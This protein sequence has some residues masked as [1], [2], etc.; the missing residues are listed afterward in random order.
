MPQTVHLSSWLAF[1]FGAPLRIG[2]YCVGDCG[3]KGEPQSYPRSFMGDCACVS[4][5]VGLVFY[6]FFGRSLRG[7]RLISRHNKR[8]LMHT[9][10]RG[11][12]I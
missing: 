5:R 8:K 12:S 6:L 10:P 2:D 7:M 11:V 3:V 4:P 9:T 1:A